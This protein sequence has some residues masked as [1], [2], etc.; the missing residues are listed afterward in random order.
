[1]ADYEDTIT[2]LQ[3]VLSH[4]EKQIEELSE[5]TS[6]Q[7]KEIDLLKRK[8][9]SLISKIEDMEIESAEDK[10]GEAKT[11][12]EIAAAEKPPHY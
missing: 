7:W 3:T 6:A 5:M 10:T 11:V 8:V 2:R 12:A 4:Q 1:M 9:S